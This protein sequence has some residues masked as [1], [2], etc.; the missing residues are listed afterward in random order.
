MADHLI[1]EPADAR[2]AADF[3]ACDFSFVVTSETVAPF[4]GPGLSGTRPVDAYRKT[5][6]TDPADLMEAAAERDAALFVS[7]A[8]GRLLGYIAL[9]KSWNGYAEIDDIA[10]DASARRL[11]V[12]AAMVDQAVQWAKD[13]RLPGLRL[14]TQSNNVAACRFYARYGFEL[15]GYDRYLYTALT[16]GTRE[17]ALYW[18]LRFDAD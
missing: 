3:A 17:V 6:D 16:P 13:R 4:D 9:S 15:A 18:Y 5:Y 1:I 7:R 12:A 10:V 11:G 14:E 8:E 2:F